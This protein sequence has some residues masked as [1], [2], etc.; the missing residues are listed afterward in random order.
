MAGYSLDKIERKTHLILW[1][2]YDVSSQILD[3][4]IDIIFV[5]ANQGASTPSITPYKI[6]FNISASI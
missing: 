3:H 6:A 2:Y 5:Y 4:E 1:F